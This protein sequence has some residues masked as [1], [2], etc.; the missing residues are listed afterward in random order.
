M[1]QEK[2]FDAVCTCL[3]HV[4]GARII[5][6]YCMHIDTVWLRR[7]WFGVVGTCL[8]DVPEA[9]TWSRSISIYSMHTESVWLSRNGLGTLVL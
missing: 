8:G 4:P 2:C 9:R 3:G 1:A 6:I 7:K 5:S